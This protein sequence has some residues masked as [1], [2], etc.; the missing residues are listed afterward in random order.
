M[1]DLDEYSSLSVSTVVKQKSK[2][3]TVGTISVHHTDYFCEDITRFATCSG[4]TYEWLKETAK[5]CHLVVMQCG[6]GSQNDR[7]G[8]GLKRYVRKLFQLPRSSLFKFGKGKDGLYSCGSSNEKNVVKYGEIKRQFCTMVST[9]QVPDTISEPKQWSTME[10]EYL[11]LS[12]SKPNPPTFKNIAVAMNKLCV[13]DREFTERDC[14]N[15]WNMLFPGSSDVN[16]TMLYLKQLTTHWPGTYYH[17]EKETG[18]GIIGS[19]KLLGLHIVFP[20]SRELMKTLSPS[21]FCDATFNVTVYHYKVVMISTFDGNN[22]HRPLMCSFIMNSN[23]PQWTTIFNIFNIRF[24]EGYLGVF[25]E[26]V[27]VSKQYF[28]FHVCS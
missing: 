2:S 8:F 6:R 21:I 16:N 12:R 23:T 18:P 3:K 27:C 13:G 10:L 1:V 22:H 7:L 24:E 11:V 17:P 9:Q 15:K 20:W 26:C 19:P 4:V 14:I 5:T 28:V 25:D